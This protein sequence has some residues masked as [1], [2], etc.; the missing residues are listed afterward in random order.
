MN[1]VD[2][3]IEANAEIAEN[4][5]KAGLSAYGLN[6]DDSSTAD[7]GATQGESNP[8][9]MIPAWHNA[10]TP[11]DL[12]KAGSTIRQFYRDW[13]E[14]GA[15][16][17]SDSYTPIKAA[18]SQN[19]QNIPP[20]SRH[21]VRVLVPGAGLGRLAFDLVQDGYRVEGNE[22]SYHQLLASHFILNRTKHAKQFAMYPWALSFSNHVS[23][24]NQLQKVLIPDIHPAS[25][26]LE[27]AQ[28]GGVDAFERMTMTATDFCVH[29]REEDQKDL[30]D[31]VATVFFIDTAPNLLLY[32]ETV[33]NCLKTGG[34]WTNVGPL[35]WHFERRAPS[36]GE[37][38]APSGR[39]QGIG[40]PGSVE[41]THEE[42]MNLLQHFDFDI[43]DSGTISGTGY[44]RDSRSM[45]QNVYKPR[46]WTARKR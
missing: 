32:M 33:R 24:E 2:E 46:R 42:V 39:Y 9:S 13:S 17:R 26:L 20:N 35:L 16:E 30:F 8:S 27:T 31:A 11:I 15:E 21:Q 36:G 41:L 5:L 23:R 40:E 25:V 38:N 19:F 14:E 22:I 3:A 37:E 1:D 4:I 34:I 43:V 44:I 18:L 6:T 12:E 29:Y 10:M 45:L 7:S 28:D